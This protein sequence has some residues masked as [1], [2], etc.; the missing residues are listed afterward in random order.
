[1]AICIAA[2]SLPHRDPLRMDITFLAGMALEEDGM[3]G[4]AEF[5]SKVLACVDICARSF[6]IKC[7]CQC[8]YYQV[9]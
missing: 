9:I 5:S 2:M 8:H 7:G 3:V 1:M 6:A 4:G